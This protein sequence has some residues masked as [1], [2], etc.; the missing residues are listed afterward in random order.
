MQ[1][2]NYRKYVFFVAIGIAFA[3]LVCRFFYL[4]VY[5]WDKY[6]NRSEKNRIRQINLP[7]PRGLIRDRHGEILVDNRPCYSVSVIPY[8]I[9]Q[10]DHTYELLSKIF[11]INPEALRRLVHEKQAGPFLPVQI[12]KDVDLSVIVELEERKLELPGVLVESE[13]M[14]IYPAGIYASHVFGYIGEITKAEL[15]V[16]ADSDYRLGDSI[17]KKGLEKQYEYELR[18]RRGISYIE[19]DAFGREVHTLKGQGEHPPLAGKDL[20]LT[21]DAE[22]QRFAEM[23]FEDKSSSSVLIDCRNGEIL[24]I[25]SKPNYDP[26]IFSGKIPT[27]VW[28]SLVNDPQ[29]PLFDRIIQSLYPPGSA[30]K[31]V[32]AAA[33]LETGACTKESKDKCVGFVRLGRRTFDCW[34]RKG[35]GNLD[36]IGAIKNSC[37]SYF[38]RLSLKVDIDTW[39]DFARRFGF[40]QPTGIDLS[41]EAQGIVPDRAYLDERYG[42]KGWTKGMNFNLGVGQGDLLVTPLQMAQFAMIIGNE[43]Y[44]YTPHLLKTIHDQRDEHGSEF[45]TSLHNI[46]GISSETYSVLKTGMY[47]AV[48]GERGTGSAC[49]LSGVDVAGKTGTAQNPHGNDHAWFIGFAPFQKPEVAICVFVENGGTGG[50]VAAPLARQV[51]EK[52]FECANKYLP[53]FT[54]LSLTER[55]ED[56]VFE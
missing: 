32:L 45:Q 31:L 39:A 9:D 27:N 2:L 24:A 28:R 6:L 29:R 25:V 11:N 16:Y 42:S 4:Q 17:G 26:E 52:Y 49:R 23:L 20:Y 22:L 10:R 40:G 5:Q 18:G 15:A 35:H 44:Y 56:I 51:L 7:P 37:N 36:L 38:Y 43:G 41:G 47:E 50:G 12:K 13:P 19:V 55:D 1:N 54:E 33:A 46:K 30:F 14:R 48:N 8:E 53:T 3:V 34:N 21:I